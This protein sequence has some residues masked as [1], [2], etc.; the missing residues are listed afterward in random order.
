MS[1][2]IDAL[3]QRG[4]PDVDE[5][6]LV[7]AVQELL[8]PRTD[9]ATL[10][11]D[12]RQFMAKHSGVQV[13]SAGT[14]AAVGRLAA[15]RIAQAAQTLETAAVAELLGVHRTRVQHLLETGDLF[16]YRHGRRNH[17]PMWQFA[18]G[19]ALP[20]LRAVLAALGAA[21]RSVINGFMTTP[22]PDLDSGSG[23]S[24]VSQWLAAGGDPV[25]VVEFVRSARDGW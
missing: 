12:Q 18:E 13:T 6:A 15:R 10:S 23:P 14:S 5:G 3:T 9:R 24:S 16:A 8:P 17:F 11:E 1:K 20:G 21:H 22:Q 25:I 4:Y 7:R 2:I 19:R